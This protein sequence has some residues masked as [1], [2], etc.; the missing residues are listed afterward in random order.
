LDRPVSGSPARSDD[1]SSELTGTICDTYF[2][3][4]Q[5]AQW[6]GSLEK[7]SLLDMHGN[8]AWPSLELSPHPGKRWLRRA[9]C[10]SRLAVLLVV[11]VALVVVLARTGVRPYGDAD[12]DAR[13]VGAVALALV[14]YIH[15]RY[16]CWVVYAAGVLCLA[17]AMYIF[18]FIAGCCSYARK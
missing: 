3:S 12:A 4:S 10:V 13:A 5:L 8:L 9:H 15:V 17:F 18:A 2:Q 7:P 1:E 16:L 11:S 14:A 6:K